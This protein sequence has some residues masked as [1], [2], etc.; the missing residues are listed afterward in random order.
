M[1]QKNCYIIIYKY[2]YISSNL[3]LFIGQEIESTY[4]EKNFSIYSIPIFNQ[5]ILIYLENSFQINIKTN[6]I[7]SSLLFSLQNNIFLFCPNSYYQFGY[8]NENKCIFSKFFQYSLFESFINKKYKGNI[9]LLKELL[10]DA[11]IQILI[12]KSIEINFLLLILN[13]NY[14]SLEMYEKIIKHCNKKYINFINI[15]NDIIDGDIIINKLIGK[16][17]KENNKEILK[18]LKKIILYSNFIYIKNQIENFNKIEKSIKK[19]SKKLFK[20]KDDIV[21]TREKIFTVLFKICSSVEDI[22]F[23]LSQSYSLNE[24]FHLINNNLN[25]FYD[26][27]NKEKK[28]IKIINYPIVSYKYDFIWVLSSICNLIKINIFDF[29]ENNI[30]SLCFNQRNI[31]LPKEY[32]EL[33][34][35]YHSIETSE[36]NDK[37]KENV[38]LSIGNCFELNQFI[39]KQKELLSFLDFLLNS[40][41][42][43]INFFQKKMKE[44]FH[45]LNINN[46]EIEDFERIKK[47]DYE[48]INNY[49]YNKALN[50]IIENISNI[51]GLK[52]ILKYYVYKKGKKNK[53]LI[54]KIVKKF[55]SLIDKL[56]KQKIENIIFLIEEIFNIQLKYKID[57]ISE[58]FFL[59]ERDLEENKFILICEYFIEHYNNEK[60]INLSKKYFLKRCELLSKL[61]KERNGEKYQLNLLTFYPNC[62]KCYN[63]LEIGIYFYNHNIYLMTKCIN[64]HYS[65]KTPE[66]FLLDIINDSKIINCINKKNGGHLLDELLFICHHCNNIFCNKCKNDHGNYIYIPLLVYDSMCLN[67]IKK[68][69]YYCIE[70]QKNLCECCLIQHENIIV[71]TLMPH[72]I[73]KLNDIIDEEE[74][75]FP[76]E[77]KKNFINL[78]KKIISII[79]K[80]KEMNLSN[81]FILPDNF[82]KTLNNYSNDNS[83]LISI[84]ENLENINDYRKIYS[85]YNKSVIYNFI[86]IINPNIEKIQIDEDNFDLRKF[87]SSIGD[88]NTNLVI[89]KFFNVDLKYKIP[90]LNKESYLDLYQD[91]YFVYN[92]GK[93]LCFINNFT[94][95][96]IS[97]LKLNKEILC[98]NF[99]KSNDIIIGYSDNTMQLIS[100]NID[101]KKLKI[102]QEIN[103]FFKF[104]E[105]DYRELLSY[106]NTEINIWA[107]ENK[108]DSIYFKKE[109]PI[110]LGEIINE[111]YDSEKKYIAISNTSIYFISKKNIHEKIEVENTLY[112]IKKLLIIENYVVVHGFTNTNTTFINL[113]ELE[114]RRNTNLFIDIG[115]VIEIDYIGNG[116]FLFL[117]SD[118]INCT[119]LVGENF[120]NFQTKE[121][122]KYI[123][124]TIILKH[125]Y[126]IKNGMICLRINY[127]EF[128]EF[129]LI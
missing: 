56:N 16:Y 34:N 7:P 39:N 41:Y 14:I 30:W 77:K 121:L 25:Y 93:S 129:F 40:V 111:V 118:K 22:N 21:I 52:K 126:I 51:K 128:E 9:N 113:I 62:H 66:R 24:Y 79:K 28:M 88:K 67:H 11:C 17:I 10:N 36:F 8:Y 72:K 50:Q 83:S 95:D 103:E 18:G 12:D 48:K 99:L 37:I 53:K 115:M 71:K 120:K 84:F 15:K 116:D 74:K 70:C 101:K 47:I 125:I 49:N 109:K 80:V 58:I 122:S 107:K 63:S 102:K 86:D 59:L 55:F 32:K 68:Y 75:D 81:Y 5:K 61:I 76:L 108:K 26:F 1:N 6:S 92:K 78:A 117:N 114:T 33:C 19:L 112:T 65:M 90:S 97:E 20:L 100:Y 64:E 23:I 119:R 94:F 82:N 85:L 104:K 105:V 91:N 57:F 110:N 43:K 54:E 89:E 106:N 3:N 87:I 2:Q 13:N 96:L 46:F 35:I 42:R 38:L 123:D 27:F 73:I 124:N 31:Y 4:D 98:F 69:Y 45:Y 44:V 29:N 127:E 60:I